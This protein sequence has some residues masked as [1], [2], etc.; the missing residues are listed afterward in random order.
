VATFLAT[1]KIETLAE[2]KSDLIEIVL[3]LVWAARGR[4]RTPSH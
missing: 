4:D 2:R 3:P 1:T